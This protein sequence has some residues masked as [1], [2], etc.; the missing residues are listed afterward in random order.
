M[1]KGKYNHVLIR[2]CSTSLSLSYTSLG[3]STDTKPNPALSME[4]IHTD[5]V[6][7]GALDYQPAYC[8]IDESLERAGRSKN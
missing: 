7:N 4:T 1:I 8:L 6:S 5:A 3:N 2:F